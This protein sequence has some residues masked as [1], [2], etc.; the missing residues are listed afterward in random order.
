VAAAGHE[1]GQ[2]HCYVIDCAS[3]SLRPLIDLPH[4]GAVVTAEDPGAVARLIARMSEE[5][6]RRQRKLAELGVSNVAEANRLGCEL[7]WI[8]LAVDGWEGFTATSE[9]FDA[10]RSVDALLRILRDSAAAGFTVLVSGDRAAL[11]IRVAATLRRKFL[12]R[13]PDLTDYAMAGIP[14]ASLPTAFVP[15]RAHCADEALEVQLAVLDT[16][17]ASQAQWTAIRRI[18]QSSPPAPP[19]AAPICIRPLPTSIARSELAA[20]DRPLPAEGLREKVLLGVGGDD[21]GPVAIDL[22]GLDQRFL[23]AGPNRSG[24]ST[25]LLTLV[26]HC[27]LAASQFLFIGRSISPLAGWATEIGVAHID[28]LADPDDAASSRQTF[29]FDGRLLLIDDA[30]T[31][32]DTMLA[33]VVTRMLERPELAVAATARSEELA[34]AFRGISAELRRSRTGLLLR[35]SVVDGELLG[36]HLPPSRQLALPGRGVLV[37]DEVRRS[38]PEGLPIQVLLPERV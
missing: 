36:I 32:Q 7:P 12:L 15:G 9:E 30:E 6:N 1:P 23:I 14:P 16:D 10:G 27:G 8:L 13:L 20:E 31:L 4:C 37:T 34:I 3:G 24:R 17:P 29:D 33:D 22:F 21:A 2:L 26:Q 19:L 35:P 18:A 5:L 28:P 25:A 38:N 11:G